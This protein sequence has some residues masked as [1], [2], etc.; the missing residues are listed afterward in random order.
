MIKLL[1]EILPLLFCLWH[2]VK[3][4][5]VT[6]YMLCLTRIGR[7]LSRTVRDQQR[8]PVAGYHMASQWR[9]FLTRVNNKTSLI[10]FIVSEWR[11]AQYRVKLQEKVLY[12]TV[13][14]KCYRITSHGSEEVPALQCQQ[15]EADGRLLF[16]AAHADGEG[17]RAVVICSEDT[18]VFIMCLAFH[19]K[20][21][22]PLFQKC[23]TKTRTRVVDIR[24]V[25]ATVGIDVCRALLGMHA[26]TGCD[27]TSAFAGKGKASALKFL[28]NNREIKYTFL[29]LGQEW[30]LSPELMDKLEAFTCL[31]YAPKASS[32]K[33]NDLRY[34]LFCAKKGDIESHRL[35]PCRDCLD[36]HA[37]RAN[38]QAGIWRRCLGQDPQVP[39]PFGRGWKIEMEEGAEQLVVDWMDGKPAPEAV[40]DLLACK[41][42]RKCV[43][44]NCECLKNG[45]KCTDYV[46]ARTG[47]IFQ[48]TRTAQTMMQI[49][50]TMSWKMTTIIRFVLNYYTK[51]I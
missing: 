10:T 44:P 13:N 48:M 8:A 3:E 34:H 16:H 33:V 15:E 17:Y 9:S 40:L 2:R 39:R 27:I 50:M 19:D 30:D 5:R 25:A 51:C 4:V 21:E 38:Y 36:K 26:Y 32:T 28:T 42:P 22:A 1:L 11:K 23:G 31:L 43:L 24:N 7:T 6:E 49:G 41:C 45:L 29:E 37:Q 35:P 47:H 18:D 14:D 12:V 46:T 20:I